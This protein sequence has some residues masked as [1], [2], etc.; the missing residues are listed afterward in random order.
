LR[1]AVVDDH[2]LVRQGI[3]YLFALEEDVEIAGEAGS[4]AEALEL[5]RLQRPD[6]I[7]VDIK[8]INENGLDL[9]KKV[10]DTG[11][12]CKFVILTSSYD[13]KDF[14]LATKLGVEGYLLKEAL[15]EEILAAVRIVR[16]GRKY[17]DPGLLELV[18][19][20]EQDEDLNELTERETEVLRLL[21]QG[22]NNKLI[23]QQLFISECTVKKHVSQIL[24]KLSLNDRTQAAL[25]INAKEQT[26]D[27]E[28]PYGSSYC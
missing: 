14:L 1:L 2:P 28:Y 3:T 7:L 16:R 18:M 20:A 27:R 6:L 17:Y 13:K 15:P 11:A 10:K 25:Y 26:K 5:I 24:S 12:D 8:L 9:V 21:G 22:L 23:A 19:N 4:L